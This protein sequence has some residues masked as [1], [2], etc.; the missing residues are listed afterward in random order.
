MQ[1]KSDKPCGIV[2]IDAGSDVY[3]PLER[4]EVHADVVDVS[5][6][7]TITQ[8]F[9]HYSPSGLLQAKYV[10]PVP[11]RAA[12]CGFEMVAADGTVI[13]AVVKENE[14]AKRAHQ[15]AIRQGYLTGLVEHVT[16][17]IFSISLGALPAH[18]MVT[19][20]ITYVLNLMDDDS[21]DQVRLQLP[22]YIG[23]RYGSPPSGMAGA[24]TV[25]PHR[26]RISVDVR[27]QG[28]VKKVASPT[29][30][31]VVTG[32]SGISHA[33]RTANY[34]SSDFLTQDFVL[35]VT[36]E[37]LDAPRA[38]NGSLAIQLN[39]VPKFNLP[40]VPEQEY[41]FLV[42]RSG[43]M[44]GQRIKTAKRA[45]VMLLRSL[46]TQGTWLN[47]VSFGS[48]SDSL[49][50]ESVP[51][52]EQSMMQAGG[53]EMRNALQQVFSLRNINIPT[54]VFV[55]TDGES[56][57]IDHT[58]QPV[59]QVV[60]AAKENAPVRVFSLGIGETTSSALCEGIARV[61]NGLCLMA[62]TAETVI[63]KC[64][65]LV[66][67]S[68][69]YILKNVSVDWGVHN[70]LTEAYR[71]G[72]GSKELKG[73]HQAPADIS[74][75]YLGNRFVVF[76]L[77]EDPSFMPPQE[78]VIR[79]QRDGQG[80]VLR[81]SVPVQIVEF[82]SEHQP[83]IQTL[84][85]R[86]A[87]MDVED[88]SRSGFTSD[89]KAL[90]IRLGTQYQLASRYTSFIAVDECTTAEVKRSSDDLVKEED[91]AN[92]PVINPCPA[93][94]RARFLK[95]APSDSDDSD[96]SDGSEDPDDPDDTD[97]SDDEVTTG[98]GQRFL[99]YMGTD[100]EDDS[101]EDDSDDHDSDKDDYDED[102]SDKDDRTAEVDAPRETE[103]GFM[104][105]IRLQSFDGSFPP[106][107]RLLSLLGGGPGVS[108]A[109]AQSPGVSDKVWAT[110]LAVACLQ[111]LLK[112]Q[113]EMLECLVEKATEFITQTPGIDMAALFSHAALLL[114]AVGDRPP[115]LFL[116]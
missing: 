78:I 28:V 79:A 98:R 104:A 44:N 97:D 102:D 22:M 69:T 34:T 82:P 43:S 13:T 74:V 71:T 27:M 103:D 91:S 90:F 54:S 26:I 2:H 30:P 8:H 25:P 51:Y 15:A 109:E 24:Q 16:D 60:G 99:R 32:P 52:D 40:P 63:G 107:D 55:F 3:L 57:N 105:L 6:R 94:S 9:W 1:L 53:T 17:D 48:H 35:V 110:A 50:C 67:A 92:K 29:H 39:I 80:E 33:A 38:P 36:A 62:T 19:T 11:S 83:L 70:D 20:K 89:S 56:Y 46:P 10:F 100:S 73:I 65:R 88:R 45:L 84:A 95:V 111:Q 112:D 37:G 47:I 93:P 85:A 42:D 14:E 77:V 7:V 115:H 12:V 66:R 64:S 23:M 96:D 106:D 21:S 4:T 58:I 61:G 59:E 87:I 18:Q 5:T 75:I 114:S 116:F 31:S 68:R 49:W 86:R 113:S 41:I 108:L 81:F 76:A 72:T 101:N